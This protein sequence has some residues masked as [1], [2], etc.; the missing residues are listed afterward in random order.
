[1]FAPRY[2]AQGFFP[3][4]YFPPSGDEIIIPPPPPVEPEPEIP[5]GGG[6]YGPGYTRQ[7]EDALKETQRRKILQDDDD[8]AGLIMAMVTKGLI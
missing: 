5:A 1:M 3:S 2:F 7:R 6:R 4:R 8:I